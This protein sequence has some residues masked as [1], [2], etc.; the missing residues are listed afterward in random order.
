MPIFAPSTHLRT[1]EVTNQP[2]PFAGYNLYLT[3]NALRE[4]AQRD[5][6][7]WIEAPLRALGEAVGTE[8]VLD[9]G[10]EA[11]RFPPELATFDLHGRRIDEV[12]FHPAYHALMR[13]ATE[14]RIHDIAWA[15]EGNGGHV[16]HAALLALFTQAEAGVMCPINMTYRSE[17]HTSRLNSSPKCAAR[18]PTNARN[19]EL[20][21]Q[22]T[23]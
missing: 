14:H 22:Q 9:M 13:L 18:M 4:A 1:H 6:G 3:D 20:T 19:K 17:E 23:A 7:G 11:N 10:M 8:E 16:A 2:G 5:G 21:Q 15:H 12:R